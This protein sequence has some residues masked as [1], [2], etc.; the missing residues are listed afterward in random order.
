M[1]GLTV[2]AYLVCLL[3]SV[4]LIYYAER[5][6]AAFIQDRLGP[7]HVGKWGMLQPFADLI[8][9]IQKEFILPKGADRVL[10]MVAPFILFTAVFTAWS[11]V[12]LF[13]IS[14]PKF[15]VGVVFALGIVGLD[16]IGLLMAGW[17]SHSKYSLIGALRTIAQM[18]SY[19]VPLTLS[20][21]C[22][23]AWLGSADLT[24][25]NQNQ[26]IGYYSWQ[27]GFLAW[28]IFQNPLLIPAFGIFYIASLA[29]CNRTPFDLPEGES[30]LVGG[31][32]TEYSG[33]RWALFFLAEY[34]LML[35]V[36]ALAALLFLGGGNSP[37]PNLGSIALNNW[38]QGGVWFFIWLMGKTLVLALTHIWVRW[39]YPRLRMDQL[40]FLGW[41][42]LTPVALANLL[43]VVISRLW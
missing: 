9:L 28:S 40:L 36:C 35:L 2:L 22:A 8:K 13:G 7:T 21:L 38:T 11:V 42:V 29:E 14:G 19:E 41:K 5:K 34:A 23:I 4:I 12:P 37:L 31:F 33:F 17:A 43:L 24:I 20:V 32:H 10:F 18:V 27:T 6:L 39:T 3:L 15:S 16:I 1:I 30:E 26:S 25:L